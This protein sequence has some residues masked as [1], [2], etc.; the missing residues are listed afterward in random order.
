MQ[1]GRFPR[2]GVEFSKCCHATASG[3]FP[4]RSSLSATPWYV[5]DLGVRMQIPPRPS[6]EHVKVLVVGERGVGKTTLWR[7]LLASYGGAR[8]FEQVNTDLCGVC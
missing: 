5:T 6:R 7:N 8:I 1:P 3:H 4:M 2:C